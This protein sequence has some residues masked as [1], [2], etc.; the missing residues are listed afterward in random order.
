MK[1]YKKPIIEVFDLKGENLM[2]G[3]TTSPQGGGPG[4]MG[5]NEAPRRRGDIID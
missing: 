2:Q 4:E 5:G 3:I 1:M